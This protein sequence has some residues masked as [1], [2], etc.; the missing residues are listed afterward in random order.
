MAERQ[1]TKEQEEIRHYCETHQLPQLLALLLNRLA[2]KKDPHPKLFSVK[3][4]ADRVSDSDLG[5]IGLYRSAP[6]GQNASCPATGAKDLIDGDDV[7][8]QNPYHADKRSWMRNHIAPDAWLQLGELRT[9]KG[10]SAVQCLLLDD[11]DDRDGNEFGID[12][13][14]GIIALSMECYDSF[15]LLFSEFL[16]FSDATLMTKSLFVLPSFPLDAMNE[17]VSSVLP[18]LTMHSS[19]RNLLLCFHRNFASFAFPPTMTVA[20]SNKVIDRVQKGINKW[21]LTKEHSLWAP[22]VEMCRGTDLL[23]RRGQVFRALLSEGMLASQGAYLD[24]TNPHRATALW[25]SPNKKVIVQVNW[26]NHLRV[27]VKISNPFDASEIVQGFQSAYSLLNCMKTRLLQGFMSR[28]GFQELLNQAHMRKLRLITP[29]DMIHVRQGRCFPFFSDGSLASSSIRALCGSDDG[30]ALLTDLLSRPPASGLV[31]VSLNTLEASDEVYTL[32]ALT[33]LVTGFLEGLKLRL[34]RPQVDPS[35]GGPHGVTRFMQPIDLA[36]SSHAF[37]KLPQLLSKRSDRKLLEK[38]E[39]DKRTEG[40]LDRASGLQALSC[41][42]GLD[43][44]HGKPS[45]GFA[46]TDDLRDYCNM[47]PTLTTVVER[48]HTTQPSA[49]K[50]AA[51]SFYLKPDANSIGGLA[52]LPSFQQFLGDFE[53]KG[54]TTVNSAAVKLVVCS[55]RRNLSFYKAPIHAT[56]EELAMTQ[57]AI[58]DAIAGMGPNIGNGGTASASGGPVDVLRHYATCKNPTSRSCSGM[59]GFLHDV[60]LGLDFSNFE[61]AIGLSTRMSRGRGVYIPPCST[62]LIALQF[63][64]HIYIQTHDGK[65]NIGQSFYRLLELAHSL[66]GH[67]SSSSVSS[68][69]RFA[70]HSSL[71]YLTTMPEFLGT[72]IQLK[73]KLYL[74][75]LLAKP[76]E[77]GI[78]EFETLCQNRNL[79]FKLV[80][81]AIF[82]QSKNSTAMVWVM[83]TVSLGVT[84]LQQLEAFIKS[85]DA[86]LELEESKAGS[87]GATPPRALAEEGEVVLPPLPEKKAASQGPTDS[88]RPK[89]APKKDIATAAGQAQWRDIRTAFGGSSQH[90]V[91]I[92]KAYRFPGDIAATDTDAFVKFRGL[93]EEVMGKPQ[94]SM[95]VLLSAASSSRALLEV[96]DMFQIAA[97][98][99]GLRKAVSLSC[100]Q[101]SNLCFITCRNFASVPFLPFLVASPSFTRY[102][103]RGLLHLA[104]VEKAVIARLTSSQDRDDPLPL[105]GQ[106]YIPVSSLTAQQQTI[107]RTR[108]FVDLPDKKM[109]A[110][111]DVLDSAYESFNFW[112]RHRG[113]IFSADQTMVCLVNFCDHVTILATCDDQE[114]LCNGM[115]ML[116]ALQS[117]QATLAVLEDRDAP[118]GLAIARRADI[119]GYAGPNLKKSVCLATS[120]A[121][122]LSVTGLK[123]ES[124]SRATAWA[125]DYRDRLEIISDWTPRD[126]PAI[127][128][129]AST[130]KEMPQHSVVVS[131]M[132]AFDHEVELLE[133]FLKILT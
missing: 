107:L 61:K 116:R 20:E 25:M 91:H 118:D 42:E 21:L 95:D 34:P 63:A 54:R 64:D 81:P 26:K 103:N 102:N 59:D 27:E 101:V 123:A 17:R 133:S 94:N 90:C 1:R 74:P 109:N 28:A 33:Q 106:R 77:T 37:T 111:K 52:P 79:G 78:R 22:D 76:E 121:A 15:H 120:I 86:I 8:F 7:P 12:A 23:R 108:F 96:F 51:E 88:P 62:W 55:L 6:T 67:F 69:D 57:D 2:Q 58:L 119:G 4:F 13:S 93:F 43:W 126:A 49:W 114:Q 47:S 11:E 82:D 124:D 122:Q 89:V 18:S 130:Q 73:A 113:V 46:C 3:Y 115:T 112:P 44:W 92:G 29:D 85:V 99:D 128:A 97:L 19:L 83:S 87:L 31:P 24:G 60:G 56:E 32:G 66:Q 70:F 71:G 117:I 80:H 110:E 125:T 53:K 48:F 75:Y 36:R 9:P 68:S 84:E 16:R 131:K 100:I 38:E 72:G 5:T 127:P 50:T 40:A 30:G 35:A 45:C 65:G 105:V 132:I 14:P 41:P 129:T 98:L 39:G 10:L 104:E